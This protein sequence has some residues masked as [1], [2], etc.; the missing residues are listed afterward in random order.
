MSR[1]ISLGLFVHD[2]RYR[3]HAGLALVRV[4]NATLD[5][6][7]GSGHDQ[8]VT[9]YYTLQLSDKWCRLPI[10]TRSIAFS[11]CS[12]LLI[13]I[14]DQHLVS[15]SHYLQAARTCFKAV[16]TI[17]RYL[18]RADAIDNQQTSLVHYC[19]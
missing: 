1:R 16:H 7:L 9:L 15:A 12:E 19:I 8:C 2:S 3:L 18:Q 6:T 4:T 17:F 10:F 13:S 11:R 14:V 5:E